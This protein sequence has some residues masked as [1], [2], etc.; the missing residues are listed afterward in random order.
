LK[1]WGGGR[2]KLGGKTWQGE[3]LM[4]K[5]VVHHDG[6]TGKK[7]EFQWEKFYIPWTIL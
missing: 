4:K 2:K 1:K 5:L 3:G 6:E 7:T